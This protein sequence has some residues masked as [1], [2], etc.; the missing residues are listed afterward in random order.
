M[1]SCENYPPYSY[2]IKISMY[3]ELKFTSI[4]VDCSYLSLTYL[5]FSY[6][7]K[8]QGGGKT[9]SPIPDIVTYISSFGEPP[10][11]Q[12][13]YNSLSRRILLFPRVFCPVVLVGVL[14]GLL[15]IF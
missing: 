8:S 11:I 3:R 15:D 13:L 6:I 9:N 4:L 5:I 1:E 10:Y 14:T 7:L 2:I 12:S